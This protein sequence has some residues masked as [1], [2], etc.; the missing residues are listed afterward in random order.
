LLES[1]LDGDHEGDADADEVDVDESEMGWD[2][3]LI[4]EEGDDH[5]DVD[6]DVDE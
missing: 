4:E 6:S 1:Q 2:E 3:L 5:M